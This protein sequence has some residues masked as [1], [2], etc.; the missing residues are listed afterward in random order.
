MLRTCY[1]ANEL[2]GYKGSIS[3]SAAFKNIIY[4]IPILQLTDSLTSPDDYGL[5]INTQVA[6]WLDS[7]SYNKHK[8]LR[9]VSGFVIVT[10]KIH[11]EFDSF[12]ASL[13]N[14]EWSNLKI[15]QLLEYWNSHARKICL[16]KINMYHNQYLQLK[17]ADVDDLC[18]W[19]LKL[20]ESFGNESSRIN[21]KE[22]DKKLHTVTVNDATDSSNDQIK[23]SKKG[24]SFWTVAGGVTLTDFDR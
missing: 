11:D 1:P 19:I 9:E 4:P 21:D 13:S 18:E 7:R 14:P 3:F 2:Q 24:G 5:Y 8:S 10:P 12:Q 23:K 22:D 16:P 20:R 17:L 6:L 15:C